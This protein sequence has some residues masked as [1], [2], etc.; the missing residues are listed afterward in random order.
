MESLKKENESLK[1]RESQLKAQLV[2]ALRK[3]KKLEEYIVYLENSG[4][5]GK[6]SM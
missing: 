6:L 3:I 1:A 4:K 2:V 5:N